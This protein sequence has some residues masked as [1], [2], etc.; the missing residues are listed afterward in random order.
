MEK[1]L[2][3]SAFWQVNKAIARHFKCNDTALL[4]SD[5][6]DAQG[7]Y[8][9]REQL[10]ADGYFFKTSEHIE[11][12]VNI[13]YRKQ[14]RCINNLKDAGF[15]ETKLAGVPAKLH[16]RIVQNKILHFVKTRVS[17][18]AKQDAAF[19]QTSNNKEKEYKER[20]EEKK[21]TPPFIEENRKALKK[22]I[23]NVRKFNSLDE[24]KTEVSRPEYADYLNQFNGWQKLKDKPAYLANFAEKHCLKEYGSAKANWKDDLKGH[25][26]NAIQYYGIPKSKYGQQQTSLTKKITNS[27]DA[28][29]EMYG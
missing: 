7:F 11:R 22:Q 9:D 1:I 20:I 18:K 10:T 19:C 25:L 15:I 6:I 16:F 2:G 17:K 14:K 13:L 21:D 26:Y 4:L 27:A 28:M 8:S 5:L 29:R 24:L 3:Q 12:D 23:A